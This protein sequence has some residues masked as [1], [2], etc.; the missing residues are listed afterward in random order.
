MNVEKHSFRPNQSTLLN[1][2]DF[3]DFVHQMTK[4]KIMSLTTELL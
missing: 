3:K 4:S 1:L 2:I